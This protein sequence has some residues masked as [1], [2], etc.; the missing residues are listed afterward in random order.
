MTQGDVFRMA[1]V[2]NGAASQ[3][4]VNVHHYEQTNV[5]LNDDG[6]FLKDAWVN[7]A[8]A[9]WQAAVSNTVTIVKFEIR[10]LTKPTFGVDFTP[11][12]AIAGTLTGDSL[13]PT[14]PAIIS[15]RTGL[16]GRSYRGR[17][18][19]PPANELQQNGGQLTGSYPVLLDAYASAMLN[20]SETTGMT[21]RM[22][23]HSD[24]AGVD[25]PVNSYV[26]PIFL[27]TQKR[28]RPGVGS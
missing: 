18:Y 1:I 4:M 16:I 15:W 28:R 21:Y 22:V 23:I 9:A 25:T 7:D 6:I 27:A 17:S 20:I 2:M 19:M 12:V 26:I 11:P 10:N 24:T 5:G 14:A 3:E 13:P 8:Q